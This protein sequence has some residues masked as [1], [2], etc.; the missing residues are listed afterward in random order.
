MGSTAI[1]VVGKASFALTDGQRDIVADK[2]RNRI[3]AIYGFLA[4]VNIGAWI[5]AI[6]AFHDK[7]ILLVWRLL[8]VFNNTR[9]LA[10]IPPEESG[11]DLLRSNEPDAVALTCQVEAPQ[12]V[13]QGC[14]TQGSAGPGEKES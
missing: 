12:S 10:R 6:I 8:T 13:V 2:L 1:L 9:Y 5:W 7:P 3:I 14:P 4:A 11:S